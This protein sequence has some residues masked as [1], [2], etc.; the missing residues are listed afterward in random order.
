MNR[1]PICSC[2]KITK[3][4]ENSCFDIKS[5]VV[6]CDQCCFV[7][8]ETQLDDNEALDF[9]K[10]KYRSSKVESFDEIRYLGDLERSISQLSFIK[11][12]LSLEDSIL[13][14]GGGWG[15]NVN[16]LY[17]KGYEKISVIE[18][19]DNIENLMN[20][21]IRREKNIGDIKS[22]NDF[23]ILSGVLE[24]LYDLNG[25]LLLKKQNLNNKGRVFVEVP[26]G[27]NHTIKESYA[28]SYHNSFFSKE[29]LI[30]LFKK[31]DFEIVKTSTFGKEKLLPDLSSEEYK[32][33]SDGV[34]KE[35]SI[36]AELP[37]S[38]K[39]AYWLRMLAKN[40]S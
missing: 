15:V 28:S 10:N 9:Y 12:S 5:N 26:N 13:E 16:Y 19:D 8:L 4:S 23:I 32:Q 29:H 7:F 17:S 22:K 25:K 39:N 27:Q 34:K 2:E 40:N 37:E 20:P 36:I 21:S 1:C 3:V 31:Y 6:T 30:S 14:I 11:D 33:W 38:H 24:H 18:L 35:I